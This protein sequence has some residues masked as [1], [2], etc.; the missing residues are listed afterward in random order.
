LEILS[1]SNMDEMAAKLRWALEHPRERDAI[2]IAGHLRT[3]AEHTYDRRLQE[4]LERALQARANRATPYHRAP[5][6][7]AL[8]RHRVNFVL[9]SVRTLLASACSLVFGSERG[10]RAARRAIFEMSWRIFGKRT[11]ASAGLPGRLF[12]EI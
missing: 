3:K 4:V 11:F 10:P 7:Q 6:N 5:F 8:G 1:Y 12:P 9:A 2:A